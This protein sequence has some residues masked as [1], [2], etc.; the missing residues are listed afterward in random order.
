CSRSA[1]SEDGPRLTRTSSER[2]DPSPRSSRRRGC[3][4]PP[5]DVIPSPAP[6]GGGPPG[7]PAHG[8]FRTRA[9]LRRRPGA[10][11]RGLGLGLATLYLSAIVLIPLAAVG[12]KAVSQGPGTLWRSITSAAALKA[13]LVTL[14]ASLLVAA[15]GAVM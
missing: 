15:G 12:V 5:A 8:V 6:A 14:V 2:L 13:L 11:S 9:R 7:A 10:R 1:R 3:P 4:L